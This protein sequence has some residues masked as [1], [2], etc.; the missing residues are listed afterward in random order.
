MVTWTITS[1]A[2]MSKVNTFIMLWSSLAT[3]AKDA[4]MSSKMVDIATVRSQDGD[5]C[6]GSNGNA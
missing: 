6:Q 4:M 2:V 3:V 1:I 5:R